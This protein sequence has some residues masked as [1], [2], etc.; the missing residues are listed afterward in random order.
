MTGILAAE[1]GVSVPAHTTALNVTN[2]A[3]SIK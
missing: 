3:L 1:H 2:L